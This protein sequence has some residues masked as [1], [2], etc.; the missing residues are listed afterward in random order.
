MS[1]SFWDICERA[2]SGPLIE[3][4]E[5]DKKLFL[6]ATELVK[7]YDIQYNKEE[8]LSTDNSLADDVWKA[9]VDLF[10]D[11]GIYCLDTERVIKI[12]EIIREQY[13]HQNKM[14]WKYTR[15]STELSRYS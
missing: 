8:I 5:F 2:R 3:E 13:H 11:N 4:R 10:L 12:K 1:L 6:R 7:D 15:F 14:E 9:G